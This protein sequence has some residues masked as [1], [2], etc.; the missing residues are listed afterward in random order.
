MTE[1][2]KTASDSNSAVKRLVMQ[3]L[4]KHLRKPGLY[5]HTCGGGGTVK[6][7]DVWTEKQD[8]TCKYQGAKNWI[9]PAC[10]GCTGLVQEEV[11]LND[12][13][14]CINQALKNFADNLVCDIKA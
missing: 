4:E 14:Y 3:I 7:V 13:D 8:Y 1:D 5:R 2:N 12:R 10:E 9:T 6:M 11:Q